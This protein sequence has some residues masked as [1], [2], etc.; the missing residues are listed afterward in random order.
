MKDLSREQRCILLMAFR[1][2]AT[3]R[4]AY[5]L[6]VELQNIFNAPITKIEVENIIKDWL[7]QAEQIKNIEFLYPQT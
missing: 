3:L 5:F 6:K 7:K 1:R 2:S 4:Q